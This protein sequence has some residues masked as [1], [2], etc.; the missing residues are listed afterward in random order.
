[1]PAIA[2]AI[3]WLAAVIGSF[4]LSMVTFL[5]QYLSKRF[6]LVTAGIALIVTVTLTFAAALEASIAAIQVVLPNS[7]FAYIGLFLPSNFNLCMTTIFTAKLLLWAYRWNTKVIQY[8]F[9]F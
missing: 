3:P 6:A 9:D 8:K 2:A 1:M 4:F 5:T 7:Y